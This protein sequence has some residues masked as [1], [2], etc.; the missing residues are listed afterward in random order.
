MKQLL[1]MISAICLA[2]TLVACGG[3]TEAI[4]SM[5]LQDVMNAL[6]EGIAEDE[7]P[8]F[9]EDTAIT[10]DNAEWY[11]GTTE[12][13]YDEGLAREPLIGSIAH[14]TVLLRVEDEKQIDATMELVRN[15]VNT[16]KWVC[17]GIDPSELIL[18][19]KGNVILMIIDAVGISDTLVSNFENIG[20]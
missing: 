16:N 14:S 18:E 12:A 7:M 13:V 19:K 4:S 11:L 2:A 9:G 15:S 6:Y 1:K 10:A 3:T 20:K 8:M 17:V 5:S